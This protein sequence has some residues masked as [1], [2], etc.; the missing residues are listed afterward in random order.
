MGDVR[1]RCSTWLGIG[2]VS[3]K[4]PDASCV[5]ST[6]DCSG[7]KLSVWVS[8]SPPTIFGEWA[9]APLFVV[10]K[11]MRW[12][13]PDLLVVQGGWGVSFTWVDAVFWD[14]LC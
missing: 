12:W 14:S 4:I 13:V 11:C 6:R 9:V 7:L 5:P 8:T 2:Q 3:G 1:M 10:T